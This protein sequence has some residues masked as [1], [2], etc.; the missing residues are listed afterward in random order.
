[1]ILWHEIVHAVFSNAALDVEENV[2]RVLAHGIVEVLGANQ[3][4]QEAGE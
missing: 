1:M 2:V 4:L 3:W